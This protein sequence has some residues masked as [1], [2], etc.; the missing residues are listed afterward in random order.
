MSKTWDLLDK[1]ETIE[2][3]KETR[4]KFW[5]KVAAQETSKK[6]FPLFPTLR[7]SFASAAVAAT[8]LF[9]VFFGER[10]EFRKM[11]NIAGH[12]LSHAYS[13]SADSLIDEIESNEKIGEYV[14]AMVAAE[15]DEKREV[16]VDSLID[17]LNEEQLEFLKTELIEAMKEGGEKDEDKEFYWDCSGSSC[18]FAA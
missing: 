16:N 18:V 15:M 17:E 4:T 1:L 10:I 8:I 3:S 7:W 11:E 6:V 13:L 2:P 12:E 5:E 9:V 14:I